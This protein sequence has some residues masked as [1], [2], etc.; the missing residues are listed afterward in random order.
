M[1]SLLLLLTVVPLPGTIA[2]DTPETRVALFSM[3]CYWSGEATVGQ[4]PGVVATRIGDL[5]GNEV[6]EVTY[7]PRRTGLSELVAALKRNSAF[8][9]LIVPDTTAKAAAAGVVPASDV[10]VEPSKA[11]FIESKYSLKTKRPDL[12]YLDLT[13]EQAIALNS[14]CYFGGRMPDVLSPQLLAKADAIRA[15]LRE[16]GAPG[17]PERSDPG[18]ARYRQRLSEWLLR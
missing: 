5:K 1:I 4:V 14:W 6:V 8:Y 18:L 17:V 10:R 12:Y 7:D 9:S 16:R 11:T 13:E 15:K 3:Y 2:P